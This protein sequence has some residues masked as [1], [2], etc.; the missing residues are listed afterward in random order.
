MASTVFTADE[1]GADVLKAIN[2]ALIN[3]NIRYEIAVNQ[4]EDV[5][6]FH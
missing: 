1:E 6:L 4:G 2:F 5:G 3:N